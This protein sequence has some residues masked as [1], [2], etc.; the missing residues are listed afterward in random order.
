MVTSLKPLL[1][2]VKVRREDLFK[3]MFVNSTV[4]F[5]WSVVNSPGLIP[6]GS[7]GQRHPVVKEK[8]ERVEK[9]TRHTNHKYRDVILVIVNLFTH[10]LAQ[11]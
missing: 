8:M 6:V 1:N 2:N 9:K 7:V 4:L 5:G 10:E 3:V 11:R